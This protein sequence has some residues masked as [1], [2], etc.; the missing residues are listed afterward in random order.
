MD[1]NVCSNIVFSLFVLF[2][3]HEHKQFCWFF[4]N[5]TRTA[6]AHYL[7]VG[8]TLCQPP[9]GCRPGR[10]TPEKPLPLPLPLLQRECSWKTN[11]YKVTSEA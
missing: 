11:I 6:K 9:D 10:Q 5:G 2:S 1:V 8:L 7:Q 3:N 4:H